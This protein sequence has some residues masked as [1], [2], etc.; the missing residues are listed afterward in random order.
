MI[1][2]DLRT[3]VR[4]EEARHVAFWEKIVQSKD[5]AKALRR[6]GSQYADGRK[7]CVHRM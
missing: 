2:K 6:V 3:Y 7:E 1:Y 4:K 5:K